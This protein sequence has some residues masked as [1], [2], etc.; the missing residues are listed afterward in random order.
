MPTILNGRDLAA[1]LRAELK[2]KVA[3]LNLTPRL[4]VI[5][6]GDD[7]A[8]HLYVALKEKAAKE[9]GIGV[10]KIL[11][12]NSAAKEDIIAKVEFFNNRPDIHGILIQLPLP[13]Q[14]NEHEIISAMNPEKDADGFHPHNLTNLQNNQTA[15]IP[16]VTAG[17]IKLI[18]LS[19]QTLA[20]KQACLI[21][22]S[23]EF[24]LPLKKLLQ[25]RVAKVNIIHTPEPKDLQVADIVVVALGQPQII[26]GEFI[27]D[28][29][30]LIDVGTTKVNGK[31]MG[32]VDA[33]SLANRDVYLTP[34]PGGVGPMT[35]VMLL[36]NVYHLARQLAEKTV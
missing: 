18:E 28:G 36:W 11:L 9:V 20:Q 6:V 26:K 35:V 33:T 8:S 24:A 27:K 12:P 4:G 22:N 32:D 23:D 25:D 34:V 3:E 29:A 19:G 2:N 1:S 7:P 14:L 17:I 16:G 15:V 30:V 21:V 5:L 13:P 10:E 31:V